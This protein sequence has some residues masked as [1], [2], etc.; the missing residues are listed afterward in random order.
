[1][2]KIPHKTVADPGFPVGGRRP[3]G[4]RQPPMHMLFS[5][6]VCENERIGSCWGG[7]PAAPPWIR[8]CKN[9]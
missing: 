4:G 6:N 1:M 7:A 2:E 8:Q 9:I 5:E 3:V